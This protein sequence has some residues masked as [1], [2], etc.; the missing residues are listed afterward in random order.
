[1]YIDTHTHIYLDQFKDDITEVMNRAKEA[2]VDKML[3][4]N[5]DSRTIESMM[6]ISDRYSNCLPMPGLHPCSVKQDYRD[7]LSIVE[8]MLIKDNYIAVGEIGIDLYWD[9]TYQ[10]EQIEAYKLQINWAKDHKIPFV[11][12]S[13]DSL[14]LTISIVEE[15]QDGN[16]KGIFHCFN[17]TN[18]EAQRIKDVGFL[19]GIGGVVTFKNAGVDKVVKNIELEHLVLETDAP[20][21]TPTPFRKHRNEPSYIPVI[22]KKIADLHEIEIEE[23]A[24]VTTENA[25]KIFNLL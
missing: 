8:K 17:G 11:I 18:E 5:V 21:L 13:R 15:L 14:D 6:E 10:L 20:Y 16:L 4:P 19:M 1:M 24:R 23:V 12:H 7:E 25:S 9:K 2:Q 22:A 3:L